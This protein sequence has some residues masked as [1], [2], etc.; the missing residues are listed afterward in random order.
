MTD[1]SPECIDR[2][3]N[4]GEELSEKGNIP[5]SSEY[6]FIPEPLQLKDMPM[7]W[8][9]Y[10]TIR[11]NRKKAIGISQTTT[12]HA[13]FFIKTLDYRIVDSTADLVVWPKVRFDI[14]QIATVPDMSCAPASDDEQ[15]VDCLILLETGDIMITEDNGLMLLEECGTVDPNTLFGADLLAWF[16]WTSQDS[17]ALQPNLASGSSVFLEQ[18]GAIALPTITTVDGERALTPNVAFGT[19]IKLN[20]SGQA[21]SITTTISVVVIAKLYTDTDGNNG[22]IIYSFNNYLNQ[23]WGFNCGYSTNDWSVGAR[24]TNA[25]TDSRVHVPAANTI[26]LSEAKMRAAYN[27]HGTAHPDRPV[28][29]Y[30]NGVLGASKNDFATDNFRQIDDIYIFLRDDNFSLNQNAY[31]PLYEVFFVKGDISLHPN[32][33]SM[34]NDYLKIKYPSIPWGSIPG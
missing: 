9:E 2:A 28:K 19:G 4:Q 14:Q 20:L 10:L 22:G 24:R 8:E 6:L 33:A 5:V 11:T 32:F 7:T 21:E 3:D 30:V 31:H 34:E 1:S 16:D 27:V 18:Q 17:V 13:K 23:G 26:P 25:P 15:D 12:G 29:D